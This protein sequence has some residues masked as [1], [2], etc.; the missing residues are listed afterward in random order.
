MVPLPGPEQREFIIKKTL[1]KDLHYKLSKSE[2]KELIELT[3]GYSA[4]DINNLVNIPPVTFSHFKEAL[5]NVK[6]SYTKN[7]LKKLTEWDDTFGSKMN[8]QKLSFQKSQ[9]QVCEQNT[10]NVKEK[11]NKNER[12]PVQK[13]ENKSFWGSLFS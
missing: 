2:M 12:S 5:A 10:D 3:D 1:G 7:S 6:P 11:E 4:S 8:V 9:E 13:Q